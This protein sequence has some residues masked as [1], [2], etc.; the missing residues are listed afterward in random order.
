MA[1]PH[2]ISPLLPSSVSNTARVTKSLIKGPLSTRQTRMMEVANLYIHQTDSELQRRFY[3][4]NL[5]RLRNDFRL[6]LSQYEAAKRDRL[7]GMK[8]GCGNEAWEA[9]TKKVN[10]KGPLLQ[11]VLDVRTYSVLSSCPPSR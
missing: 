7:S 4:E 1:S 2:E 3:I 10:G 5:E 9:L 8:R 6:L 11:K